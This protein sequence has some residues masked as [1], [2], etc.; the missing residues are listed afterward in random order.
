MQDALAWVDDDS[1]RV[2]V[3]FSKDDGSPGEALFDG[4]GSWSFD[5][6]A[7]VMPEDFGENFAAVSAKEAEKAIQAASVASLNARE[8]S[9]R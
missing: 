6:E 7:V 1:G 5:A 9:Q 3:S 4:V 2:L 8:G